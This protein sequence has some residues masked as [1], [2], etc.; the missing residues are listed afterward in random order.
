MKKTQSSKLRKDKFKVSGMIGRVPSA[1]I[2][3]I[4][5]NET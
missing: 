2:I 5:H 4:I 1:K 3:L